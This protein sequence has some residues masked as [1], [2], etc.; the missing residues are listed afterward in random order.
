MLRVQVIGRSAFQGEEAAEKSKQDFE[1]IIQETNKIIE[2]LKPHMVRWQWQRG[3]GKGTEW[4]CREG[5]I[6][7]PAN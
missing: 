3:R 5:Y 6:P 4:M 7:V 1:C 2:A